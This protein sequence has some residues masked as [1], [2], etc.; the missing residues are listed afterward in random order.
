M[1]QADRGGCES[2]KT[3]RDRPAGEGELRGGEDDTSLEHRADPSFWDDYEDLPER[4]QD[5]AD[6]K[7][8]LL[9]KNS[10]HPSLDFKPVG[11]TAHGKLYRAKV[12]QKKYRTIALRVEEGVY[13]WFFIGTHDDYE[14]IIN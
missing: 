3:G 7:F 6:R 11:E 14:R 4:I 1:G 8:E 12:T 2:G 10:N 13:A 9:K 5:T